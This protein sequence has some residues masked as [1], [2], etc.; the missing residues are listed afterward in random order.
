MTFTENTTLQA[1]DA[2]YKRSNICGNCI[3][4][5]LAHTFDQN[6][7]TYVCNLCH[8]FCDPMT[9]GTIHRSS[10]AKPQKQEPAPVELTGT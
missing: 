9:F 1:T 4:H 3:H 6:S 8:K 10:F 7:G 2:S 5:K